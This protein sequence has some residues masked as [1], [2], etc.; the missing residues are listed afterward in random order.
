MNS[1]SLETLEGNYSQV[2]T[3]VLSILCNLHCGESIRLELRN[4]SKFHMMGT[5]LM[6]SMNFN[7]SIIES[8]R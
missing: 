2:I 5:G 3:S 8:M 7:T 6:S 1:D 4:I